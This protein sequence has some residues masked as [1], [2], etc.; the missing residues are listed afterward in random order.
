MKTFLNLGMIFEFSQRVLNFVERVPFRL[1]REMVDPILIDGI[2]GKLK[3]IAINTMEI[4]RENSQVLKFIFL[5]N[6]IFLLGFNWNIFVDF[7]RSYF[8]ICRNENC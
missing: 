1:T 2:D 6:K 8:N 5:K 3:T 7:T 4:L